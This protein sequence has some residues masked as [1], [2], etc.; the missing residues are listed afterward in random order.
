MNGVSEIMELSALEN[1]STAFFRSGATVFA[2]KRE[3]Q[4]V[5]HT[6]A[7][8]MGWV[9]IDGKRYHDAVCGVVRSGRSLHKI[10][11][12]QSVL[13]AAGHYA[14][15]AAHFVERAPYFPT[16]GPTFRIEYDFRPI[17]EGDGLQIAMIADSH[18]HTDAPT[19][20][21]AHFGDALDLLVLCGD[22]GN[23]AHDEKNSFTVYRLAENLT[24]GSRPVVFARGNHDTR[25][26]FA[27]YL[28]EY[29]GSDDGRCYFTF[30]LGSLWGVVLDCGEDKSDDHAEYG[31]IADFEAFRRV[32]TEFLRNVVLHKEEEYAAPGVTRRVAICHIPFTLQTGSDFAGE[33]YRE[34]IDLLNT[35]GI[36]LM[37]SGHNHMIATLS[38][39]E[40]LGDVKTEARFPVVIGAKSCD[41]PNLR[42]QPPVPDGKKEFTC[43]AID[44]Q[45]SDAEIK[46][47]NSLQEIVAET[48]LSEISA[49]K[50]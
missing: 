4:I 49:E 45:E 19:R 29:M 23:T 13:D 2:V 20:A 44:W 11:V 40:T 3:Y 32:E 15:C 38:P 7:P 21:A 50:A 17:D 33:A 22:I 18:S 24:K 16:P 30:R 27:E 10:T 39:H 47:V 6:I 26:A 34:W 35:I 37:L 36:D 1:P 25:G 28:P 43:T 48:R 14:I 12:P 46:F 31:P 8:A 5:F 42:N 9:E 41:H